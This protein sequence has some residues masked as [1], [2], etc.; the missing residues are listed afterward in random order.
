MAALADEAD[1][2]LEQLLAMYGMVVDE[3]KAPKPESEADGGA[4]EPTEGRRSRSSKRRKLA[5]GK[6]SPLLY[7]STSPLC[8]SHPARLACYLEHCTTYA[9]CPPEYSFGT[10]C[11]KARVCCTMGPKDAAC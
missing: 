7:A 8:C 4:Q 9:P 6:L 1:M 3:D 5:S 10:S 2:P 11:Q